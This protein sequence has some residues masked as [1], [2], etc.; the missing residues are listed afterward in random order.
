MKA[1]LLSLY[2]SPFCRALGILSSLV[3]L[4]AAAG[5]VD[6]W[7]GKNG[8]ATSPVDPVEWA[9]GNAGANNSHF[10]EGFSIPY[11]LVITGITPGAH[12]IEIG[13]D[14]RQG[15]KPAIDYI[16]HYD[17]LLPHIY[18][19][20]HTNAESI[21]P[22]DGLAGTFSTPETFPIPEPSTNGTP[23]VGQPLTSFSALPPEER[24]FTIWN[25]T[26]TNA[27]YTV[28]ETLAGTASATTLAIDF[29]T[30]NE[31]V[32]LAWG[33]HIASMF[34]WGPGNSAAGISGS[35]YHMRLI[36]L[37]G[38]GGRQDRSLAALAIISPPSCELAGPASICATT[39]NVY[40]V[41][42]D[43]SSPQI[44]WSLLENTAGAEIIG[45]ANT[46]TVSIRA[47]TA[48]V[49]TLAVTVNNGFASSVCSNSISVTP[50]LT[51]TCP[52]DVTVE[53]P[54]DV[55]APAPDSV[56]VNGAKGTA[57]VT[58]V[59]DAL[60]TTPT[61]GII[62]RTYSAVDACGIT[63]FCDQ[64]ITAHDSIP[65][66]IVSC[67]MDT[68]IEC[69]AQPQ[70][71]MPVFQDNCDTDLT[72]TFVDEPVAIS[73][74]G[75]CI[76]GDA[77]RRTWTAVDDA[78][79]R[80]S[81]S[82][83]I[84]TTDTTVPV[85]VSCPPDEVIECPA[86]P[87]FGTP[88]F[89]D[90]CDANLSVVHAD[91]S[92]TVT[93]PGKCV[94][95]AVKRTWTATDDCG[96]ATTCSQTISVVDTTPAAIV[97]CPPDE[98]IECPA[99]PQFGTPVFSDTCD[100]DLSV[101]HADESVSVTLPGKCVVRA[102]K[103]TWTATDDCGNAT[104]CSQTISVV[105]TTPAA[106]VSCPP[107]QVIE[108][109]AEP[110]FG[111]PAFSDACDADLLVTHADASV[112]LDLPGRRIVRATRRTW[113]ASDDCGNMMTC[114][115]TIAIEDSV[116]PAI[117]CP[118]DITLLEN[119][120]DSGGAP[121][122]FADPVASD[123]CDS[124]LNVVC[125]PPSG[126]VFQVGDTVVTCT[127]TDIGGN[128]TPCTFTVRVV[129][130]T[131]KVGSTS[132]SGPGTLRQAMLDANAAMGPN[133]IAF[134]FPGEPPYTI[135]L[136]SPLP[137]LN[138]AL[139]ING[140]SQ[141]AIHSVEVNGG[142]IDPPVNIGLLITSAG[143]TIRGLILNGFD[144]GIQLDGSGGNV[145]EGNLI[146]T[147]GSNSSHGI[148]IHSA[149]NL[150]GGTNAS[151]RN[152]ISGNGG[153]GIRLEGSNATANVI[154]GNYI[155]VAT[156]GASPLGNGLDGLTLA[157]G[158]ADNT[159]GPNNVIAYNRRN[160][161]GFEASAGTGN[162][163]FGNSIFGNTDLPIDIGI[164]GRDMNDPGDPDPG[165]NQKQNSPVLTSARSDGFQ[166]LM[167]QGSLASGANS[168]YQIEM[169]LNTPGTESA[170]PTQTSLGITPV[171]TD[172]SGFAA[173][174]VTYPVGVTVGK[175]ITATAT[176][177]SNNT[178]EFSEP[179]GVATPPIILVHPITTNAAPGGAVEIC[180]TVTGSEP[181][182]FRWRLNGANIPDATN[183]CYLITAAQLLHG[184]TY[185]VVIA[186]EFG[187]VT[188]DPAPLL[189]Q[190][191]QRAAGDNYADSVRLVLTNGVVT[192]TNVFATF[193]EGEPLHAG[194]PG[195][196]SV[197]YVWRA[198]ANGIAE[199]RTSGSTFDTL[200]GI[201]T[202][203]TLTSLVPVASDE[204]RGGFYTSGARFN[205][206]KDVDYQ[207]AIDGFGGTSGTFI[208]EWQFVETDV[209][210]PVIT[211]QPISQTV[212]PGGTA[213]FAVGALEGCRQGAVAA[214]AA[215]GSD[216]ANPATTCDN[217]FTIGLVNTT[218]NGSLV[219]FS[220]EVC[221]LPNQ[222]QRLSHVA[223]SLGHLAACLKPGST[224]D[225][226]LSACTSGS[227]E[228]RVE[229]D[230]TTTIYGV[231]FQDLSEGDTCSTH[232]FTLDTSHLVTGPNLGIGCIL[233]ATKAGNQV[234]DG[235]VAACGV[236]F[237]CVA[238]P[239]CPDLTYQWCLNGVAIPGATGP[240]YTVE[241][242]AES[243]L[244]YYTVK[245]AD[246]DVVVESLAA[247]LQ[248]NT[249][250][251]S[252]QTVL[253]EDKFLNSVNALEV[254]TLGTTP[255]PPAFE[256][257]EGIA[258]SVAAS[259]VRGYTG[260][261]V[262]NTSGSFSE[263]EVICGVIGGSSS[264]IP[265]LAAESGMLHL[266]TDGSSFDTV[267]AVYLRSGAGGRTLVDC[268][269]NSGVDGRD[270]SLTIPINGG[271][272]NF[273]VIDGVNGTTGT[274][275][276]NYSLITSASLAPLGLT[277]QGARQLRVL[278]HADMRFTIEGSAN[279]IE[280]TP[281]LTTNSPTATFDFIDA[282]SSPIRFYRAIMLP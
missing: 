119:P 225:D 197:W 254:L 166:T 261:Q 214:S 227:P 143:N 98:V 274:L 155:G 107:D 279:L 27:T 29:I 10:S 62:T 157:D 148:V 51:L 123:I 168:V 152:V 177:S 183:D 17:R 246:G 96:N 236:G 230:P 263:G 220:Y 259:V 268:D 61:G 58:H 195:G 121:V 223:V 162:R 71:G 266:N 3:A 52:A 33:G 153:S 35:P 44:E 95:R 209:C 242:A 53:C 203:N 258:L 170:P 216:C 60:V 54:G 12:R 187:A 48:G 174:S 46:D 77:L 115:Q 93:V 146:G 255:Q 222:Q 24:L 49:F 14:T 271:E 69:P 75:K 182:M 128:V 180:V 110:Q 47:A 163:V 200:L 65:P 186:N 221:R 241:N 26:I 158:A 234:S 55:P 25:G 8:A 248:F 250:G 109:P 175:T 90:A 267:M 192:S 36:G 188:S 67:P 217:G 167:V 156:D 84:S 134:N 39:T 132:D 120:V 103:R 265:F 91:E 4:S 178:S 244:G 101:V 9:K 136:L 74:P 114:A 34:D 83:T 172:A 145:V 6:L 111:T 215:C 198:P 231:K 151:S 277:A 23:V 224:L 204:D 97:S 233:A 160:G 11:R 125:V 42:T 82:Q 129:P 282:A 78:G 21:N 100:A 278:G 269:N 159:V 66:A 226:L 99:E 116:P 137:P 5:T 138:D 141:L 85:L 86:E 207:I 280:W 185:T 199:F 104:T 127:A 57:T 194:K 211:S 210:L 64:R 232:S 41:T 2:K 32:V 249:T 140:F 218:V 181:L 118:S 262:F 1:S 276:L 133:V 73:L 113:T 87:Q 130:E 142:T 38:A 68:T 28:E 150:I 196:K 105:D 154:L 81:C 201:Y 273:I 179:I 15:G 92:V 22:L 147:M 16:T 190:V 171:T 239:V 256:A 272:T 149:G 245:V 161:I 184:G 164:N 173:I 88:V 202:G 281:L 94:V 253:A 76:L 208:F 80:T 165:P 117:V 124:N 264:W 122:T 213:I 139:V 108:C 56:T 189:V 63:V 72:V 30:T 206:R 13:W 257:P 79:N 18:F 135:S 238:G 70:F 50:L 131:I 212:L 31:T 37:D 126:S 205:A 229:Q 59:G 251:G 89:S 270:S 235:D 191:P 7:Q 252:L 45:P 102:V 247:Q 219:T 169:F 20:G 237:A 228:C 176:D 243:D 144:V 40:T 275:K 112:T 106:V 43:A 19:A 193:E 260:T 240:I